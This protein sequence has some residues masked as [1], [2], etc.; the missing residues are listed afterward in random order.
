MTADQCA[1]PRSAVCATTR[2]FS[3]KQHADSA[4]FG[5]DTM[6]ALSTRIFEDFTPRPARGRAAATQKALLTLPESDTS[7]LSIRAKALVFND[8]ASA[9]LLVH[10]ERIARSGATAL[11]I[12]ET[13]T[14]KELVARHIHTCSGRRGPFVAVNCGAFSENLVEAELFGHESGAFT[15]ANQARAGWF[16]AANGGT[17]FLDEIGD[18]PLSMQVKLLRVL[19]ERQVVRVGS[20]TPIP[21]DVRLVAA[22][23]VDLA[24][25]TVAGHFRT[26]LYYRLNVAQVNVP[27]LRE[28][29]GDIL[30]LAQYFLERFSRKQGYEDATISKCAECALLNYEWPGNIRELENVIHYALIVSTDG[31]ITIDDLR[32]PGRMAEAAKVVNERSYSPDEALQDTLDE[33]LKNDTPDLFE[34]VQRKLVEVAM[35][36]NRHNQVH[37]A[38]ALGVSRNVLRTLLQ[39]YDML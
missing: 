7:A 28:R 36:R 30:P 4:S 21:V 31:V 10:I 37:S 16:E 9:Q 22:T 24:R 34:V 39:R 12:G 14:G 15:G 1:T 23:N 33:L 35:A 13:G 38:R 19:Q 3:E 11:I 27:P 2:P 18:L 5:D 6:D 25:A 20:R 29:T 26:D 17:L 8:P 32:L